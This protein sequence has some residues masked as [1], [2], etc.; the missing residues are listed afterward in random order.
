MNLPNP[1]LKTPAIE[2]SRDF[3]HHSWAAW[4]SDIYRVLK[5]QITADATYQ[6]VNPVTYTYISTHWRF[7]EE[8]ITLN[9]II[10]YSATGAVPWT[11]KGRWF[12]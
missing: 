12:L 9:L 1:P 3:I 2:G 11:E 4:F 10:E 7:H 6:P 8:A 5:N